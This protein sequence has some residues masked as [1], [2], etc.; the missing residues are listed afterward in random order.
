MDDRGR[1]LATLRMR[2]PVLA[3]L[4]RRAGRRLPRFIFDY[5]QGGVGDEMSPLR[6]RAA[7]SAIEIVPRYGLDIA[8][9][10]TS[11]SLFGRSYQAPVVIAPVGMDGA[12][13]PNAS[14]LLAQAARDAQIPYMAGAMAAERLE[15]AAQLAPESLWFQLY[16]FPD[17]DH[18]VSFDLIR[19]AK[20]AGAH[21]LAVTVDI[22]APA[23]RV[24]D[25]RNGI[26]IPFGMTAAMMLQAVSSP[27]WMLRMA[28]HGLPRFAN[29]ADY[30]GAGAGKAEIDRFVAGGRPGSGVDWSMLARFRDAWAGAMI[31]KGILHPA[32]AER[33]AALGIDGV[34]VSNH[35]GRQFD[36]APAPIDVLPAV[37]AA[38][39][40]R[41]QVLMDGGIMSGLDILKALACGADAVVVGRAFMLGLAALGDDGACHVAETLKE[42][43]LVALRQTGACDIPGAATLAV[44]HAN[45][46][47]PGEFEPKC[48][49]RTTYETVEG[50]KT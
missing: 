27:L 23:R 5:L 13:W 10:K 15:T 9:A 6:N 50:V 48:E 38:V 29:L 11:V 46:W 3:D 20:V 19:R 43:L 17:E 34:V 47:D 4:E 39:G 30:C 18:R 24:R 41:M 8:A 26:R 33:A 21:V 44:R 36:A 45:A 40:S 14:R 37:R 16:G 32:D 28:R 7:L 25:M 22:P 1:R 2:Y 12:I 42:E 35:G 31:V 49:I